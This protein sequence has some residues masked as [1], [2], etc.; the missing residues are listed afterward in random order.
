MYS[1]PPGRADRTPRPNQIR[2]C[3]QPRAWPD[4]VS[5]RRAWMPAEFLRPGGMDATAGAT[6]AVFR[7]SR[8]EGVLART[9]PGGRGGMVMPRYSGAHHAAIAAG[10]ENTVCPGRGLRYSAMARPRAGDCPRRVSEANVSRVLPRLSFFCG[11][12]GSSAASFFVAAAPVEPGLF[13]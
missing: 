8:G 5:P 11:C 2:G 4:G 6:E 13:S 10:P 9:G 3:T 7:R 12:R 1:P